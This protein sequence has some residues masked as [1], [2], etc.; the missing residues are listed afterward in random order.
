MAHDAAPVEDEAGI[1]QR[2][3]KMAD[4]RRPVRPPGRQRRRRHVLWTRRRHDGDEDDDC[5]HDRQRGDR[6]DG[7]GERQ[8]QEDGGGG[9]EQ[10]AVPDQPRDGARREGR[11]RVCSELAAAMGWG[12]V[13][14]TGPD[15]SGR[16]IMPP[17]RRH[18]VGS[19]RRSI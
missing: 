11:R 13:S 16:G 5:R 12:S 8:Q 1:G 9:G 3:G 2:V 7:A 6:I 18:A 17:I 19:G 10:A 4:A 14:R 15:L